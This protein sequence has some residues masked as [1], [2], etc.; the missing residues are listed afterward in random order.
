MMP[1]RK[2]KWWNH[3]VAPHPSP[4]PILPIRWGDWSLH[5]VQS[6]KGGNPEVVASFSPTPKELYHSAQP[7][8]V[9]LQVVSL[10]APPG[11]PL[12][13]SSQRLVTLTLED[14]ATDLPVRKKGGVTALRRHRLVRVCCEA[15]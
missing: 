8:Q 3:P 9:S 7:G 4:L 5:I 2:E 13:Q 1:V 10:E 12:R 11:P 15:F 14:P 6:E